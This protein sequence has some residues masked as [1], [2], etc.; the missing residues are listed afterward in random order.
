MTLGQVLSQL[1]LPERVAIVSVKLGKE[2]YYV[3]LELLEKAQLM[4]IINLKA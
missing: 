3:C 2:K 4:N 1:S